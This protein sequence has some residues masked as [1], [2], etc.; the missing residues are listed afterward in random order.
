MTTT[1]PVTGLHAHLASR[2]DV[3]ARA[4]AEVLAD[5]PAD[6]FAREI[7]SV[8]TAGVERWLSQALSTRL[9]AGDTNDGVSAGID[10][11]GL[12]RLVRDIMAAAV[13]V[14]VET[15]PWQPHRLV[16]PVLATMDE[17]RDEPWFAVVAEHL[18]GG[19]GR[20]PGRRFRIARRVATVFGSY[21]DQRPEQLQEWSAGG[22]AVPRDLEWQPHLWRALCRRIGDPSG[23]AD[24]AVRRLRENPSLVDLPPRLSVFGPTRLSTTEVRILAAVGAHRAV[25]LWLPQAS[26][27]Q[28]HTTPDDPLGPRRPTP[29]TG[30]PMVAGLGRDSRELARVLKQVPH[31]VHEHPD[32]AAEQRSTLLAA[33]Q[34]DVIA[35]RPPRAD[36]DL[37]ADD[38]SVQFHASHGPERQVEVLREVVLGLLTDDSSLE[39]RDIVVMCPDI[40]VYAPHISAAFA[41]STLDG[42]DPH[43]PVHRIPVRLADRSLRQVNPVLAVLQQ[44][45][46]LVHQRARASGLLALCAAEP[47]ARRFRFTAENLEE[48]TDLVSAAEIRWG[49]DN[50]DVARHGMGAFQVN[51]WLSGLDRML[52][53]V[54]VPDERTVG[55]VAP[56][57]ID[58][59][60]LVD[61]VGR[62]AELI[63][64]LRRISLDFAGVNPDA[65]ERK[66]LTE[67]TASMRRALELITEVA[68]GEDWQVHH[69]YATLAD[70]ADGADPDGPELSAADVS[71]LLADAFRGRPT[72]ASFR[73]GALTMC[74]LSPMRSVPHRVVVLLGVDDGRF[75][76][77][78]ASVGDDLLVRD[79]RE[80]ER[81]GPGEDRQLLLDA[82]MSATETLVVVHADR[83]PLTN[84]SVPMSIPLAD[85]FD[86]ITDT[87][88]VATRQRWSARHHKHPLQPFAPS[89]FDP[90]APLSFDPQGLAG[91]RALLGSRTPAPRPIDL[92]ATLPPIDTDTVELAELVSFFGDPLK[93]F[94]A[95][96]GLPTWEEHLDQHAEQLT[97]ELDG[98]Q[99]WHL[100][101]RVLTA[102]LE[103][104]PPETISLR[105]ARSGTL[106]PLALGRSLIDQAVRDMLDI[107]HTAESFGGPAREPH[108]V[109]VS[110]GDVVL[111]GVVPVTGT[112][113][114][115]INPSKRKAKHE[116][117]LWL[118]HLALCAGSPD[119]TWDSILV[120]HPGS[121]LFR[122]ARFRPVPADR[123]CEYLTE[124]VQLYRDG[125]SRLVRLPPELARDWQTRNQHRPFDWADRWKWVDRKTWQKHF[126]DHRDFWGTEHPEDS[127]FVAL[128]ERVWGP[129][130][131]HEEQR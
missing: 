90:V 49:I 37:S 36:H 40:E 26:P 3:L 81:D 35:G 88:S 56:L 113:H 92:T 118:H 46:D 117:D 9:G 114:L 119:R 41:G 109:R 128:A 65:T 24:E 108:P 111:T 110:L 7:V 75:P 131:A 57:D 39:P 72:R 12:R 115:Q 78:D 94:L 99:K 55:S 129:L 53:G 6:P 19:A 38:R 17:V 97:A 83:D 101:N 27:A 64:R 130:L 120:T 32:P 47:V 14:D 58:S 122:M 16:W 87:V 29:P 73:T 18:S 21:L 51:T 105:E 52:T 30:H 107:L 86:T 112:R 103:G 71:E 23:R 10:F 59:S 34:A 124:L 13:G 28:W 125:L 33:V 91:A 25:H 45:L 5:P 43:H 116:M 70:L 85:V 63:T 84:R 44:L 96:R 62:F 67:W 127:E 31:T 93:Q 80:G 22:N 106:P 104:T 20:R 68:P 121:Y 1:E 77:S 61:L 76:R 82:V 42:V 95:A 98:L 8:P 74:T 54:A 89:Y 2:A 60:S 50:T 123:A 69:A 48:I 102:L 66:P 15:D 126:T 11:P 4:L 100:H 79:P